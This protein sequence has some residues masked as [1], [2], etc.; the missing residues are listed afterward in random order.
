MSVLYKEANKD[1]IIGPSVCD[2]QVG[3]LLVPSVSETDPEGYLNVF[4][5]PEGIAIIEGT[6]SNRIEQDFSILK[7]EVLP[8]SSSH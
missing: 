2:L 5:R 8:D 4:E 6:A 7:Y 3:R 1:P